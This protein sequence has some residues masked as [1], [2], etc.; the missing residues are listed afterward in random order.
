MNSDLNVRLSSFGLDEETLKRARKVGAK[1]VGELDGVL[2]KLYAHISSAPSTSDF[3]SSSAHMEKAKQLQKRHWTMLLSCEF[4]DEYLASTK[5]IGEVHFRIQLPFLHYLSAY[6]RASAD[7][8]TQ[9]LTSSNM[10]LTAGSRR[11]MGEDLGILTR[12]FA[13]DTELVIDAYF[14]AQAAEQNLAFSYLSQGLNGLARRN[15]NM[16][17]PS[18]ETSDYPV[19]YDGL[20]VA[21]N[22][23][24]QNMRES[25]EVFGNST[26]S[27][28]NYSHEMADS[29]ND[30]SARTE[31]QAATLEETAAAMQ[32]IT[33]SLKSSTEVTNETE[34]VVMKARAGATQGGE[35]AEKAIVAM[36]EIEASSEKIAQIIGMIDEISFQTS[37]LAADAGVEAARAGDAGRGFAVVATE[38]RALAQRSAD[39]AKDIKALI[40]DSALQV[41][42]GSGLVS[43][44]GGALSQITKDVNS[45]TEM[46]SEVAGSA[47]EQSHGVEEINTAVVQLDNVTQHNAAMV[48]ETT[49]LASHLRNEVDSLIALVTS[50]DYGD[51]REIQ[52]ETSEVSGSAHVSSTAAAA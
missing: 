23:A 51:P 38:V 41:Q 50:F 52:A 49:A 26:A 22:E 14:G 20:R 12:L 7:I 31:S 16:V 3:F 10:L 28:K 21:F 8:Q 48:E 13:L 37:L 40:S 24:A 44:A 27:L 2:D 35:L 43:D 36:Q 46:I 30:L 34:T 29:A 15:L 1:A 25:L 11:A 9:F 42:S 19:R 39:A 18:P 47:K 4:S 33:S 6:S 17:I 45:V 32:E 5:R